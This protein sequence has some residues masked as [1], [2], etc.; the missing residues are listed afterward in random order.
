MDKK[1]RPQ[2]KSLKCLS[3]IS[4]QCKL[5]LPNNCFS[6]IME[7]FTVKKFI[8]LALYTASKFPRKEN[9][10]LLCLVYKGT[11]VNSHVVV[12]TAVVGF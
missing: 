5:G 8:S 1:Q 3:K 4:L 11:V 10:Y 12:S 7:G 6:K 9:R 2:W